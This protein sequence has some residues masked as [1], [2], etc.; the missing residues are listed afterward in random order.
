MAYHRTFRVAGYGQTGPDRSVDRSYILPTIERFD[1]NAE[2]HLDTSCL[3]RY[4]S[5]ANFAQGGLCT[6]SGLHN[7][8]PE[9][10]LQ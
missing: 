5:F 4:V 6:I 3:S 10:M 9:G 8:R 1:M 2:M 7:V